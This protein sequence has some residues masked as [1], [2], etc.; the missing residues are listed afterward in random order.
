M[1]GGHAGPRISHLGFSQTEG[2][3]LAEAGFGRRRWAGPIAWGPCGRELVPDW[4]RLSPSRINSRPRNPD[5]DGPLEHGAGDFCG[6]ELVPDGIGSQPYS[7]P[8][9]IETDILDQSCAQW[10]GHDIA[11]YCLPILFRSAQVIMIALFPNRTLSG[12]VPVDSL[13]RASLETFHDLAQGW[14]VTQS[15]KPVNMIRHDN[16]T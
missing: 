11:S 1:K 10:V 7:I 12:Q 4:L 14:T 3:G 5:V 13:R 15:E 6:R 9:R 8:V 16:E 2:L